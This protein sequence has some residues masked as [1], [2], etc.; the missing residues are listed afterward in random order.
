M[1]GVGAGG[2]GVAS[3]SAH[4]VDFVAGLG[5]RDALGVFGAISEAGFG[6]FV[7]DVALM[8][9]VELRLALEIRF[10]PGAARDKKSEEK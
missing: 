7:A 5:F 2:V 8:A 3:G 10:N 9:A 4:E 1:G 6:V